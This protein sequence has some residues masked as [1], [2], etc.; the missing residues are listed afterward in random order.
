MDRYFTCEDFT[1]PDR[2]ATRKRF[3]VVDTLTS[4]VVGVFTG[5]EAEAHAELYALA[6]EDA[7][8]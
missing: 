3:E 5:P 1:F 2:S 8:R 6:K 4:K 7:V